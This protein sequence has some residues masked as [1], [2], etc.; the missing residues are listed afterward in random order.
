MAEHGAVREQPVE[1]GADEGL[2]RRIQCIWA[3]PLFQEGLRANECLE[4]D[5]IFC[6]HDYSHLLD[7]ARLALIEN[8]ETEAGIP[9]YMIYAAA[10]LHDIGRHLQYTEQLPHQEASARLAQRILPECG[11]SAEETD[12]ILRAILA[13]RDSGIRDDDGLSGLIFRADKRSRCCF[14]CPA[15]GQCNW[16][17]T[18]K[19]M[20]LRG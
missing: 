3:H 8:L 5:R 14:A 12:Q 19:N 2:D 4:Q 11:F 20:R 13:H 16:D 9:K 15:E 7:V 17:R 18:K 1:T 6:K 10:L